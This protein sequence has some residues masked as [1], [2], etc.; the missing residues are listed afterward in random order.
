MGKFS[1]LLAALGLLLL[2]QVASALDPIQPAA[3]PVAAATRLGWSALPG[4]VVSDEYGDAVALGDSIYAVSFWQDPKRLLTR[5][6][7]SSF[8][9]E[10]VA[11]V[12]HEAFSGQVK[13]ATVGGDL[14]LVNADNLMRL[15]A[16]AKSFTQLARQAPAHRST[17]FAVAGTADSLYVIGGTANIGGA[18]R[19][20]ATVDVYV[21][22]ANGWT[23]GPSLPVELTSLR[24]AVSGSDVYVVGFPV[25]SPNVATVYVL[26]SG[27]ASWEKVT[28]FQPPSLLRALAVRSQ[29]LTF[30]YGDGVREY[31]IG[32]GLWS[33]GPAPFCDIFNTRPVLDSRHSGMDYFPAVVGDDVYLFGGNFNSRFLRTCY[34]ADGAQLLGGMLFV[35]GPDRDD[36]RLLD[37][38][39]QALGSDPDR[40]D[41]D[42]DGYLDSQEVLANYSPTAPSHPVSRAAVSARL[43]KILLD[44]EGRGQLWYV[45]PVTSRRYTISSGD[46]IA[47]LVR[48]LGQGIGER[49]AAALPGTSRARSLAGRF[50]IHPERHGAISYLDPRTLKL[51]HLTADATGIQTLARLAIGVRQRDLA[52]IPV[53]AQAYVRFLP[54]VR[55]FLRSQAAFN[56]AVAGVCSSQDI[57]RQSCVSTDLEAA[58][59]RFYNEEASRQ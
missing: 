57:A 6:T 39:E 46:D 5:Y 25:S 43:G 8:S 41:S 9:W 28:E 11:E 7:P 58:L 32:N 1:S 56:A 53:G 38:Y 15:D 55:S 10:R 33:D 36:D 34:G 30:F 13:L 12:P 19:S 18:Y 50:F 40:S 45:D 14:Y 26:H 17:D 31:T 16:T 23:S 3:L 51:V 29:R 44:V 27:A 47:A 35:Y 49:D 42:G 54:Q 4:M 24:A 37:S 59:W 52:G 21:P 48:S 20:I 22:A 2:P